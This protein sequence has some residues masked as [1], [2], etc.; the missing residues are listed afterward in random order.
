LRQRFPR[1]IVDE[2]S[3]HSVSLVETLF[4]QFWAE[5]RTL[6]EVSLHVPGLATSRIA[7]LFL[8]RDEFLVLPFTLFSR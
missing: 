4:F 8:L 6:V 3:T 1:N 7:L 5:E 2:P